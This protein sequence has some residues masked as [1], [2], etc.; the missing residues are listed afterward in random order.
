MLWSFL[1][2]NWSILHIWTLFN[3]N[4]IQYCQSIFNL[5]RCRLGCPVYILKD[6]KLKFLTFTF[7][8]YQL[9][10]SSNTANLLKL[11]W[12]CNGF[13]C[14]FVKTIYDVRL[15]T[16]LLCFINFVL[17]QFLIV[18]SVPRTSFRMI[19]FTP[20]QAKQVGR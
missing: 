6:V 13:H 17:K 7:S 4:L 9:K 2:N 19:N 14:L 10:R 16:S 5:M 8:K 18:I 3:T 1:A 12:L 15:K 11:P 20:L